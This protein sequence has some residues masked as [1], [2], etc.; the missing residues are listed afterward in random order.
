MA[1]TLLMISGVIVLISMIISFIRLI[2][3]PDYINRIVAFDSLTIISISL[4]LFI[5]FFL[6]RYT[7]LDVALVYGLLSFL[8]VIAI[9]RFSEKGGFK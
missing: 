1:N 6:K 9:A 3:G 5:S 4:I 2:I 8:G 7:Y